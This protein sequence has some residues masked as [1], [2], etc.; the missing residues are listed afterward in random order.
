MARLRFMS[1]PKSRPVPRAGPAHALPPPAGPGSSARAPATDVWEH[2]G[3]PA[4]TRRG[5][6]RAPRPRRGPA[7]RGAAGAH[8]RRRAPRPRST[9]KTPLR[10]PGARASPWAQVSKASASRELRARREPR[11]SSRAQPGPR[12]VQRLTGGVRRRGTTSEARNRSRA[13]RD[14]A[15]SGRDSGQRASSASA[16]TD[17]RSPRSARDALRV[18][19]A[20]RRAA[21]HHVEAP[22]GLGPGAAREQRGR[23]TGR[24]HLERGPRSATGSRIVRS[25]PRVRRA[26]AG[27]VPV[28]LE[29]QRP[30]RSDTAGSTSA[31]RPST[32]LRSGCPWSSMYTPRPSAVRVMTAPATWTSMTASN[33]KAVEPG[34][35]RQAR[36]ELRGDQVT[37]VE[38]QRAPRPGVEQSHEV[39]HVQRTLAPDHHRVLQRQRDRRARRPRG[40]R[41]RRRPPAPAALKGGGR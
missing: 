33:G 30:E 16:V 18:V 38:H 11:T 20:R 39:E 31:R 40:A 19:L 28:A 17:S 14:G 13:E 2:G 5:H 27:G 12:R 23:P 7:P 34:L 15:S 21:V 22:P 29:H 32:S 9:A 24:R 4:P 35:Q 3:A 25:V 6:P 1:D 36:G 37:H 41:A 26:A 8:A 10:P